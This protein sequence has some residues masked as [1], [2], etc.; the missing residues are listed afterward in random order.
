MDKIE[1]NTQA[2]TG[3]DDSNAIGKKL[4]IL[5]SNIDRDAKRLY[6]FQNIDFEQRWFGVLNQLIL[7]GPS[8]VRRLANALEISHASVSETRKSLESRTHAT[9]YFG[10]TRTKSRNFRQ[11]YKLRQIPPQ[12]PPQYWQ[13]RIWPIGKLSSHKKSEKRKSSYEFKR[14]RS[15][16]SCKL[17]LQRKRRNRRSLQ[18][19]LQPSSHSASL[20][21]S[22]RD[23][24]RGY[25]WSCSCVRLL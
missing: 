12:T 5:S 14:L 2:L 22:R 21:W 15:G 23:L 18:Q 16:R 20:A 11:G 6:E 7:D 13:P 25:E 8:T 4:R 9:R 3:F 1:F 10:S 24:A 17:S 19:S